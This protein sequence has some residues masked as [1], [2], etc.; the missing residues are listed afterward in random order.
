MRTFSLLF[1]DSLN[2]LSQSDRLTN[3]LLVGLCVLYILFSL[4]SYA[5][6]YASTQNEDKHS[7]Q[8]RM[9][10]DFTKKW[11]NGLSLHFG[12]DLRFD[13]VSSTT[14]ETSSATYTSLLGPDFNK[15]YTTLSLAYKHPHFSYLKADA[16]YTL[17]LTKKDSLLVNKIM[18]HRLFFGI[19]VSYRYENW[20]FS[21]RERFMT[22]IRM[23]DIDQHYATGYYQNN[24]ADWSLRSKVEVEYHAVSKP[25]KPYIWCELVNTLNA[26]PLQQYYTNNDPT[27]NGQ[28]YIRR[29]RTGI[30]VVWKLNSVSSL[31]FYYR[32]NYGYERDINVK[33]NKQTIHLTEEREFQHAIGVAYHFSH[34]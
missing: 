9:E 19:T 7:A 28:Q 21:L 17:K 6:D 3:I 5:W 16:G 20:S 4:P 33:P 25:L 22:E 14:Y 18:R 30:G 12:E 2:K 24:R 29:V 32:F 10:A 23:G 31:D 34:K 8:L 26:N 11:K 15:S 1:R 13:M 27:Q